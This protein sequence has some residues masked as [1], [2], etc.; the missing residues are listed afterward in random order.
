MSDRLRYVLCG[1]ALLGMAVGAAVDVPQTTALIFLA[2]AVA[3]FA[4]ARREGES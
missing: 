1:Y 4:L 2:A 3:F